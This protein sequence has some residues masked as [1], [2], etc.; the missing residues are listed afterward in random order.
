[1]GRLEAHE[2]LRTDA[3]CAQPEALVAGLGDN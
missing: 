3:F 1:M 2:V